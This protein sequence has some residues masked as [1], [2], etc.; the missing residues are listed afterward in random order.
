MKFVPGCTM[1]LLLAGLGASSATACTIPMA[2]SKQ[3]RADAR[4]ADNFDREQKR[5]K[6]D[7]NIVI[8]GTL[9]VKRDYPLDEDYEIETGVI[10]IEQTLRGSASG[11][12]DV[13]FFSFDLGRPCS[14]QFVPEE[15]VKAKYFVSGNFIVAAESLEAA[16]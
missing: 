9:S 15:G 13:K 3:A 6:R 12:L 2:G 5:A 4:E 7:A 8:V 16:E 14:P 11:S 10:D 1:A